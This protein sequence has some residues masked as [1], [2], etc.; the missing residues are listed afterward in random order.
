MAKPRPKATITDSLNRTRSATRASWGK[1][2]TLPSGRIQASYVGPDEQ[3][4]TAPSTFS[5]R[6]DAEVWLAGKRAAIA[7]GAWRSPAD[8]K[9]EA[10]TA[11]AAADAVPTFRAY[12]ERW[13]TERKVKGA[14]LSPR[15][16]D[17]YASLLAQYLLPMFGDVKVDAITPAMV[18]V[19]YDDFKTARSR[20]QGRAVSGETTRVRTYSFAR[21][22]MNT[23]VSAHGPIV[24]AVNPFA[25]RGAGSKKSAKR[26]ELASGADIAA[27]LATIRPE[28]RALVLLALWCGLR[29]GEAVELRRS[30]VDLDAGLVRVSRAVTR[31]RAEGVLTKAPK[32]EA[33]VRDV[34]IPDE[35]VPALREHL[36]SMPMN[37]RDGLLFPGAGGEHLAPSAFYGKVGGTGWYAAR[38]AAGRDDLHF[39]DLRATGATLLAQGGATE[40]EIMA[41]LGD[42][43]PQAAQR[44][45]RAARS[46]MK[47]HAAAMSKLAASGDW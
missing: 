31:S 11:R 22:V 41:W 2:R 21:A 33:G 24:G 14:P 18:N 26:T 34:H 30:D 4:H 6:G 9:A 40:A 19:W 3:R 36:R 39:H 44:Y 37:G 38:H 47:A 27:I 25:V 23:A 12:A 17:L 5:T 46:R 28:W 45:V 13:I 29:F 1:L 35:I 42:S 7:N 16:R 20:H 43:T 10:A 8:V 32:S 15:T